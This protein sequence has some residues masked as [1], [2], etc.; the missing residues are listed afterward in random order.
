LV[1]KAAK[2]E[3]KDTIDVAGASGAQYRFRLV[4]DPQRPPIG[5]GNYV[6]IKHGDE[7]DEVVGCGVTNSLPAA[8][9]TWASSPR[10]R[11]ATAFYAR[12]NVSRSVR[13]AELADIAEGHG[14]TIVASEDG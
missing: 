14:A 1:S 5:A 12:L 3:P 10:Q 11:G 2:I 8:A 4:A 9:A 6:Y 13:E 7:A